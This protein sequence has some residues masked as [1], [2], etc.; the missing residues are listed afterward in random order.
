MIAIFNKYLEKRKLKIAKDKKDKENYRMEQAEIDS[1]HT[2][3]DLLEDTWFILAVLRNSEV[4]VLAQC[5]KLS[6]AYRIITEVYKQFDQFELSRKHNWILTT[7]RLYHIKDKE[8]HINYLENIWI[9]LG[10]LRHFK[11]FTFAQREKINEA[12]QIVSEIYKEFDQS[13]YW[14]DDFGG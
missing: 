5:K 2:N 4:F 10:G 9:S 8:T 1:K 7:D 12:H 6:E 14:G 13:K 3:I 11:T